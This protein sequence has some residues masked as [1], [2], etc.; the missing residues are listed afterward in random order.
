MGRDRQDSDCRVGST[1]EVTIDSSLTTDNFISA[2]EGTES[3]ER[4]ERELL[5]HE[6]F[7]RVGTAH[8]FTK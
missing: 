2:T 4:I 1:H 5:N 3:A 6:F 7:C 8:R